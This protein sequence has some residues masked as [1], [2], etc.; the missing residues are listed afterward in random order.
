MQEIYTTIISTFIINNNCV[1]I[2]INEDAV[3][4]LSS[5]KKHF[6]EV[7]A[8]IKTPALKSIIDF[9]NTSFAN[10]PKESMEYMAN[11]EYTNNNS[12]LA[13]IINGLP[14]KLIG[15]FYLN[16]MKPKRN[17]KIFT[18]KK[19]ATAWLKTIN[20]NTTA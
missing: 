10:I 1:E 4:D 11:N 16:V 8:V 17:T 2:T 20:E 9:S 6:E 13:I 18:S 12:S 7:Y 3:F 15:N 5:V 19:E 14:Q